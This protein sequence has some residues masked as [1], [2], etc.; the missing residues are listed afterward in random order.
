MKYGRYDIEKKQ[1]N[2]TAEKV[3]QKAGLTLLRLFLVAVF[4]LVIAGVCAGY[5]MMQ[6]LLKSAPDIS[7]LSTAPVEMATYIYSAEAENSY[8][9][10]GYA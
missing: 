7:A 4:A 5:G 9:V 2:M 8:S 3:E 1:R 6:G 10:Q